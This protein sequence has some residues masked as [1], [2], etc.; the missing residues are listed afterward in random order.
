MWPVVRE[1][2]QQASEILAFLLTERSERS[3]E[4]CSAVAPKPLREPLTLFRER[5]PGASRVLRIRLAQ[6][7]AASDA[8][9]DQ[10][11][12]PRLVHADGFADRADAERFI[13]GREGLEHPNECWRATASCGRIRPLPGIGDTRPPVRAVMPSP[14]PPRPLSGVHAAP[15]SSGASAPPSEPRECLGN[16]IGRRVGCGIARRGGGCRGFS[17]HRIE[18]T[19]HLTCNECPCHTTY[20]CNMTS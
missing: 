5:D 2:A 16:R 6:D 14:G 19:C 1:F 10:P 11:R 13:R 17:A 12:G 4:G 20:T 9:L 18:F 15:G 3:A 8:L 7:H